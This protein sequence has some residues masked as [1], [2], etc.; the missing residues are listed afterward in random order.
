MTAGTS[1]PDPR[2][3][4]EEARPGMRDFERRGSQGAFGIVPDFF[5]PADPVIALMIAPHVVA[6]RE[7]RVALDGL[8]IECLAFGL[9]ILER[10]ILEIEVERFAIFADGPDAWRRGAENGTDA[11]DENCDPEQTHM[12]KRRCQ[13]TIE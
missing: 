2:V 3:L 6:A 12:A 1:L 8:A 4:L 9:P 13:L 7:N 10:A 5:E 11:E